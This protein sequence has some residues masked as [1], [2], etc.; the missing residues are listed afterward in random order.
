MPSL[1]LWLWLGV[2]VM[3]MMDNTCINTVTAFVGVTTVSS[4][5]RWETRTR[6]FLSTTVPTTRFPLVLRTAH[7]VDVDVEDGT[8]LNI[9][10]IEEDDEGESSKTTTGTTTT[11]QKKKKTS[12]WD[13]L[14]AKIKNRIIKEGQER[15]I[16]NKKKREPAQDKK[17]RT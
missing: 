16:A 15:A 10:W 17:R 2:V 4:T 6:N 13:Q 14:N 1:P 9:R 12:R 7:D 11:T 8:D 3:M 5:R